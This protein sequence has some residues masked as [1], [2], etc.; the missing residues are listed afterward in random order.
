M[1]KGGRLR[2]GSAAPPTNVPQARVAKEAVEQEQ[3][4]IAQEKATKMMQVSNALT[5]CCADAT[6]VLGHGIRTCI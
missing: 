4:Q 6:A 5:L 3:G 2:L 1:G